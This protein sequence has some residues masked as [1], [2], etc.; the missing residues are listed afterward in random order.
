MKSKSEDEGGG[1]GEGE[2]ECG[3]SWGC[4]SR[5]SNHP[6]VQCECRYREQKQVCGMKSGRGFV[7]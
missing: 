4:N 1:E 3:D 7:H 2:D 5:R 6:N